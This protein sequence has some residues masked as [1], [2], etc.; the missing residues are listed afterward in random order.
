MGPPRPAR[1]GR[2]LLFIVPLLEFV[3]GTPLLA[4]MMAPFGLAKGIC[5]FTAEL[6]TTPV[7]ALADGFEPPS[8]SCM[9]KDKGWWGSEFP[10]VAIAGVAPL[11]IVCEAVVGA[12]A[13]GEVASE[14]GAT[15]VALAGVAPLTIVCGA[16]M[17]ATA[18]GE[19]ASA[20]GATT[21]LDESVTTS[22]AGASA[23]SEAGAAT[24]AATGEDS[25]SRTRA[26]VAHVVAIANN[27]RQNVA[28]SI[29]IGDIGLEERKR[30]R[31]WFLQA[32]VFFSS[33]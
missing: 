33:V 32:F 31:G 21:G 7:T 17:G 8:K 11:T 28:L 16:V 15:T 9:K 27:S 29:A 20:T 5:P 19:V 24:G 13:G 4:G 10:T 26:E 25:S 6:V 23:G 3:M 1:K 22:A 2:L 30:M 18:G 14:T 12:T